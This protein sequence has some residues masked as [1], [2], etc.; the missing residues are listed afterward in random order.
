ERRRAH[1]AAGV[2]AVGREEQ[3]VVTAGDRKSTRLNSSHANISDAVF[4]LKKKIERRGEPRDAF[5]RAAPREHPE[6]ASR[7]CGVRTGKPGLH[8]LRLRFSPLEPVLFF[9][10]IRRPPRPTALPYSTLFR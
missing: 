7:C 4:C 2:P 6:H 8:A 3:A 10:R 9:L 5:R 1:R